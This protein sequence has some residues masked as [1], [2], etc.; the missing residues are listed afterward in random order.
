MLSNTTI[1]AESV[2]DETAAQALQQ[3]GLPGAQQ[4]ASASSAAAKPP[5]SAAWSDMA[6]DSGALGGTA[7]SMAWSSG[8]AGAGNGSLWG[9]GGLDEPRGAYLPEGLL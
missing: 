6:G 7:T 2:T 5:A 4:P 3:L 1:M 9:T 8:G